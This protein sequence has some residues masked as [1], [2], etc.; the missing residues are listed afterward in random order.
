MYESIIK[1]YKEQDARKVFAHFGW[2]SDCGETWE[3]PFQKL[4]QK[5]KTEKWNFDYARFIKDTVNYPILSSYLNSTFLRLQQQN[6]IKFSIDGDKSCFNTGLQTREGSDIFATFYKTKDPALRGHPDWT[7]FGFFETSSSRVRD[8]DPLPDIATYISDPSDLVF[9]ASY[10][11]E[12]NYEHILTQNKEKLPSILQLNPTLARN[13]VE[14]AIRQLKDRFRRNYKLA[15]PSWSEGRVQ[16]L[17]P[18]SI[19]DDKF[20]DAALV[21]EKDARHAKYIIHDILSLDSA[22]LNARIICA[23]DRH[24]LTP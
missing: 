13:A 21:A 5:A 19:T 6:K 11:F 23:P 8:F 7:L 10:E 1:R 9:D 15:V 4:A 24:W 17:L 14:G 12:I 16:L 3:T 2:R 20:S 18:L 22:Y